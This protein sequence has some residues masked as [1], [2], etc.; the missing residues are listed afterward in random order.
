MPEALIHEVLIGY[1]RPP[2]EN[3]VEVYDVDCFGRCAG[4]ITRRTSPRN[5][6]PTPGWFVRIEEWSHLL[7][8][9]DNNVCYYPTPEAAIAA[10]HKALRGPA[11]S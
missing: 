7:R 9:E 3:G 8:G 5:E 1:P 4:Q 2:Q 11:P 10:M 6:R